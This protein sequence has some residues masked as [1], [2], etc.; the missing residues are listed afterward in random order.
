LR[1]AAIVTLLCAI[2]PAA[3]FALGQQSVDLASVSGR[4]TDPSGA[5]VTDAQ[6]TVRQEQTNVT[7]TT[8]TDQEGRFRL[9]YLSVGLYEI[10]VHESGFRDA[11]HQ[12]AVRAGAAFEFPVTLSV[13]GID[14]TVTVTADVTVLEAARSQIAATLLESEIRSL[15]MNGRNFLELA[16]LVP[17]V[18]PTNVGSAQVFPETSAV[19]G[20]TLSVASQRNLSNNFIVD[21]LSANDDAAGLSGIAYGVDG[22]E[23][24][25]VVTSG[26]QAELGRALGGYVNVVTKSG[27]N[28]LHGTLYDYLRDDRFNA[29]NPLLGATLPMSQMQ[30][31]GS[32]GGPV[33]ANRTFYFANVERRRLDQTGLTTISDANARVINARLAAV[34]YGG[35]LVATG[36][37][38]NPVDTTNVFGKIGHQV[39]GRDQL[40]VRYGLYDVSAENSRGTGGLNAPSASSRLDSRDQTIA[41]S[42]TLT[43]SPRTVLETRAQ[44]AHSNLQ[45]PA[46]DPIGPAVS[47]AGAAS[48][49][50]SSS[51]PTRRVNDLYQVVNNL[52]HQAGAHALRAG[53]D[54]LF[55][56]DRITYPRA[57]RGSY[58]FSSM[59]NFVAGVYNN[60]GFTQTFGASEVAQTNPNLAVYL[61]DEWKLTPQITLN[62]GLRYDVQFLETIHTDTNNVSP[63]V[64][65]AWSPFDSRRTL[66]RGSGG[67]FFDRVPMRALANALLSAGNTTDLGNLRQ[68]GVS[69]SPTQVG[70]P[71]FPNILPAVVPSLIPVS[72][73]TM[74]RNL[75]NADSRQASVEVEQQL[76]ARATIGVGY[77]YLRGLHLLMSI[78]QNVPTCGA[79]GTNNG[80]RP[81]PSYGNNSQYSA[82]G[83]SNYHG[84][85][86]SFTQR[87]AAWGHY[88]VSYTLSKS[89]NNVG[90]FFFSSPI[91]PFDVSKDWGRSD[92]D[93]RHRLVISGALESPNKVPTS[94]IEHLTHGLQLSAMLQAYSAWPLNITSGVTT[95]QGTTGRPIVDGAFIPRNAGDG[96]DFLNLNLRLS[97]TFHLSGRVQLEGLAEGFNLTNHVNV[98]TR[99]GNFGAGAYP[100]NPSPTFGQI[101]AVGE[102]RAFQF[103]ARVRF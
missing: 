102:P 61:Q 35:P 99:N 36:L 29:G 88:R 96:S 25:Q 103:G 30:Y 66:I 93:Q 6:V 75:Q 94:L 26:A 92:D 74:D 14:T 12:L 28:L 44:F 17:G 47:I 16:L 39:S 59:G 43:L 86:V 65:V 11:V 23:Q 89:M 76:G 27:T 72:L 85:H 7:T 48:F 62:L 60:G 22:I 31:G 84:L 53:V 64:G 2:G 77:E 24:F 69:L 13:S 10:T 9:P 78:N 32:V 57:Q 98:L 58:T 45:A 100:S 81:N 91:D 68:V 8:T 90:E 40:N 71:S 70:A 87:P 41:L 73:S 20:V 4:V 5:V 19:P 42:N 34:G 82:A 46:T 3:P 38:L 55:N 80:C 52:S 15:P 54:F 21:G 37:Y 49:G 51:S 95:I 67:L 63:R 18:S 50:T 79:S 97:R 33:L 56:D 83:E 101:T 1:V